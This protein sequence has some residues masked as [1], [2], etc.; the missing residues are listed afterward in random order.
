MVDPHRVGE[1]HLVGQLADDRE[2]PL[3]RPHQRWDQAA[4]SSTATREHAEL[5]TPVPPMNNTLSL[6]I[7]QR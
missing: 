7:P 4:A 3:R 6:A 1:Q 2:N 5:M